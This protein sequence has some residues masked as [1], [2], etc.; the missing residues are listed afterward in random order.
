M[1]AVA[2]IR[3]AHPSAFWLRG[4]RPAEPVSFDPVTKVWNVY[5]HADVLRILNDP[6]IFSSEVQRKI[7]VDD[8]VNVGNLLRMDG[9]PHNRMRKIVSRVFTPRSV[10]ALEP[11]I[12][13]LTSELLDRVA[14]RDRFDLVEELACPLPLI[15]IA[16]LMGVPAEDRPLFQ[17]WVDM[18]FR[19]QQE[20]SLADD[21][22]APAVMDGAAEVLRYIGDHVADRRLRPRD[23][24]LTRLVEAEVD[25]ERLS[26]AEVKN[27]GFV[28][29][30]AGYV[31]T[32]MLLGNAVLCLDAF[33]EWQARTRADRSLVPDVI[34]ES[35]RMLPPFSALVRLTN[36][37]VELS[38]TLI[39]ADELVMIW[40]AAANR[41]ETAFPDPDTF[42]PTRD[43][44]NH[45]SFGRGIHFCV[46][47]PLGR[48]EGRIALNML[49][50]RFPDLRTDPDDGPRFR[51][52]A[53][54]TGVDRLPL[55]IGD[56]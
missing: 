51:D 1:V 7:P 19:D 44:N 13:E 16:E 14:G 45:L 9:L 53:I 12:A 48:A 39:P 36:E 40:L 27:F 37:A 49:L 32:T 8:R 29:L 56:L 47:A 33:P 21:D 6:A 35:L 4:E 24:L 5:G 20:V 26:D 34:E 52:I 54:M 11:R 17:H 3:G 15:V 31:T 30:L 18:M 50:D 55:V 25:G 38:G 41:D 28:L 2:G 43:P 46:G 42:D 22:A 10:A 23:D